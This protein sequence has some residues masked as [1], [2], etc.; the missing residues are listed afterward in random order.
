MSGAKW[1]HLITKG[2]VGVV[3]VMDSKQGQNS[4]QNS[5]PHRDGVGIV[6]ASDHSVTR[7]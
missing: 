3:T 1:Q 4:N 6:S 7:K 2:K 5:L